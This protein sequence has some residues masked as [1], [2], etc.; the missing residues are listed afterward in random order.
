M[1][2]MIKEMKRKVLAGTLAL[3]VIL[4]GMTGTSTV[5]ADEQ[6][7]EEKV[8]G[9]IVY[10]DDLTKEQRNK[11][12][13]MFDMESADDF[14]ISTCTNAQEHEAFDKYLDKKVIGTRAVSSIQMVP[15]EEGTGITVKMDNINYC[16]V[17]MYQ[18]ALISAGVEDV[19]VHVAAPF[20]VSGTCAL[21]S[22][23]N[24]YELMSGEKLDDEAVDTAVDELVTTGKIGD[25]I[26]DNDQAAEL[27]A[28]LKQ[29][30]AENPD[31]L[32]DDQLKKLIED[33]ASEMKISLDDE[34]MELLKELLVRLQNIDLNVETLKKQAGNLYEKVE[35]LVKNV[36]IEI[37][38]VDKEQAMNFL[39]KLFHA[40]LRLLGVEK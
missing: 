37:P 33:T 26:G 9:Y 21:V 18:N 15:A 23:M 13:A 7:S 30:L 22:A 3:G 2:K 8:T 12:T 35:K 17:E 5:Y 4:G 6:K 24:A 40:L 27:I 20:E 38:N 16:T 14:E 28:A 32:T 31:K 36:D 25:A 10:G 29:Q 11:V 19:A 1:N 34:T 39:E